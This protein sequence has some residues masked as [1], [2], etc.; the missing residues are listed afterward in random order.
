LESK[1]RNIKT[2]LSIIAAVAEMGRENIR[3]QTMAGR[4]QK[5]REGKWNGG[6]ASYGY[7]LEN[8]ELVIAEDEVEI[9]QM[10]FERY[11]HTN[12]GING[13]ANYLNTHGYTKKLRQNRTIPGFSSS[14][15][16][17]IIDNPV[18]MG[19]IAYGRRRTEKKTGTRNETHI[20]EQS[21]FPVYEGIHEANLDVTDIHYDKKISDLQ[22]R[23][24]TQYDKIDE[25]EEAIADLKSQVYEL[26]KN[27]IDADSRKVQRRRRRQS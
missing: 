3:V 19:K 22:R 18:Y 8:G 11:I 17:K 12:D 7:K 24:D 27:Q 20:V 23:L 10:I 9:I 15:I 1:Q 5:A 25:V 2:E 26:K 16:K 14:F 21:E 13:V 4:E 6:F